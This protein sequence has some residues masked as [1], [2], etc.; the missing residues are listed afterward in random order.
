[1][2]RTVQEEREILESFDSLVKE[3]N[4]G[5]REAFDKYHDSKMFNTLPYG[6]HWYIEVNDDCQFES[7]YYYS[8]DGEDRLFIKQNGEGLFYLGP[9]IALLKKNAIRYDAMEYFLDNK[10]EVRQLLRKLNEPKGDEEN[11]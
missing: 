3:V 1:M 9:K 7:I 2:D 11:A 4:N 5:F 10:A 8:K 6:L